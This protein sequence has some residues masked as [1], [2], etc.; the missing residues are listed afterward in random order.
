MLRDSS[1]SGGV[2]R[3]ITDMSI[4]QKDELFV[5]ALAGGNDALSGIFKSSDEGDTWTQ[6]FSA[7]ANTGARSFLLIG[8]SVVLMGTYNRGIYRS[9]N[10][11][12]TWAPAEGTTGFNEIVSIVS[13]SGAIVL[14][15]S[16]GSGVLRSADHGQSWTQS[17]DGLGNLFV[18]T[19]SR[20][21]NGMLFA[22]TERGGFVSQDHGQSW[23]GVTSADRISTVR[24]IFAEAGSPYYLT[25]DAGVF[26]TSALVATSSPEE[27]NPNT[28]NQF[29]LFP[30]YPNPFNPSTTIAFGLPSRSYV[31]LKIY[32]VMGK[33]VSTLVS[34]EL[35]A[36]NYRRQ[37]NAVGCPSG[38][39]FYRLQAG[40]H[41]ETKRLVVLK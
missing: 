12:A 3:Q 15:A 6:L 20:L 19:I 27:T 37:W 32:D 28:P 22:G 8:D 36:G 2:S 4:N 41:M 35:P 1:W 33:E 25:T 23:Q 10:L 31:S 14:A 38:V 21:P 39:Y 30:N 24:S 9:T 5:S 16:R 26:R 29:V 17:N 11:G 7:P 13:D 40:A 34:E 18:R